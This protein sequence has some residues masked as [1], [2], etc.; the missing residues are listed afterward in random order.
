MS[1]QWLRSFSS[2][3]FQ[4]ICPNRTIHIIIIIFSVYILARELLT[5]NC[6]YDTHI[7]LSRGQAQQ[8]SIDIILLLSTTTAQQS[9]RN[10]HSTASKQDS[11]SC[12]KQVNPALDPTVARGSESLRAAIYTYTSYDYHDHALLQQTLS[13]SSQEGLW[14]DMI[15]TL[16]KQKTKATYFPVFSVGKTSSAK[17]GIWL[18]WYSL[19]NLCY[20]A[21]VRTSTRILRDF[22]VHTSYSYSH[23][24]SVRETAA[25]SD[26]SSSRKASM[27]YRAIYYLL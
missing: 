18:R 14:Y 1:R 25:V 8:V 5:S 15:C 13:T 9:R 22:G 11:S 20:T 26:T 6:Y 4:T 27:W 19:W 12:I 10:V 23:G 17:K 21:A 24:R 3:R 16:P 2:T 7:F